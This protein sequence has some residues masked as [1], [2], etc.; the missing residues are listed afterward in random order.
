MI[1]VLGLHGFRTNANVMRLQASKLLQ[2]CK[3]LNFA[4]YEFEFTF[5]DGTS[6]AQG[7]IDP[8]VA[9][10][11]PDETFYEWWDSVEDEKGQKRY[12][13][14]METVAN[15]RQYTAQEGPFDVY[16]GFS[17]GACLAT[18]LAADAVARSKVD[19]SILP[20]RMLLLF[21]GISPAEGAIGGCTIG[22][23]GHGAQRTQGKQK[24]KVGDLRI[25][26][27]KRGL[28]TK[29]LKAALEQRLQADQ[30]LQAGRNGYNG[31]TADWLPT[32]ENPLLLPS[33]HV[34]GTG[35][36]GECM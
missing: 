10:R 35:D 31:H 27:R 29:G 26:L 25:E 21:C 30:R 22:D 19:S 34:L 15:L 2:A 6:A 14:A 23:G 4:Q 33:V 17:Q 9:A 24:M 20:P 16:M 36:E 11:F 5:I 13:G 32:A 1:R 28:E 12:V 3:A 7:K 18:I 8:A